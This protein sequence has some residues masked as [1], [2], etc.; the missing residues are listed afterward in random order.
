[1]PFAAVTS[2]ARRSVQTAVLLWHIAA[3][4]I[5]FCPPLL[6][7]LSLRDNGWTTTGGAYV[8]TEEGALVA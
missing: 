7:L 8:N 6:S 4:S 3:S 5:R 1:M 2:F